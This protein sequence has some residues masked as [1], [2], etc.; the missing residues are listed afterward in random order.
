MINKHDQISVP[1]K[2]GQL[3]IVSPDG[4]VL[5]SIS[6]TAGIY[7]AQRFLKYQQDGLVLA[8]GAG[9]DVFAPPSRSKILQCPTAFESAVVPSYVPSEAKKTADLMEAILRK[10]N[11]QARKI[12]ASANKRVTQDQRRQHDADKAERE[13]QREADKKHPVIEELADDDKTGPAKK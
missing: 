1:T 3:N 9:V 6:L 11:L 5:A 4:E 7:P 8:A 12:V 10:A 2:G 13:A